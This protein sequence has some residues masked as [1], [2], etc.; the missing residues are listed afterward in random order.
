M[1]TSESPSPPGQRIHILPPHEARKIAAGEVIDRPAALVREFLDNAIDS[2]ATEIDV[3]VE[4]GGRSRVEVTDNGEGMSRDD[5]LLCRLPHATSKIHSLD[6]L[7]SSRTLG[8]R[9]E[10]LAAAAAV[11]RLEILSS[12]DGREAWLLTS[13]P[14]DGRSAL[15]PATRTAGTSV[16]ALGLFDT[17]PARKRFLKRES[18]EGA[19]CRHAFLD[20]ALAFPER[21]FRFTVDG[22]LKDYLP[23]APA[24]ERFART[25]LTGNEDAFLHEIAA[26]GDGFAM[27]ILIGGPEL[28]RPDKRRQYIFAN[29]RRI[30]DYSLLQALEYGV[31]GWFPNG[32]HPQERYTWT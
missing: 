20:K 24:K 7:S 8:F 6:D 2:G 19:L 27:T 16:R 15:T 10:A 14:G 4:A 23:P 22:R 28:H 11:A 21:A 5:L 3:N 30:W 1:T 25:I 17:I 12:T 32:T 26:A 31:Q 9:G 18:S 13:E 29:R